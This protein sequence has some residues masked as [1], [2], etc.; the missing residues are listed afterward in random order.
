MTFHRS[1]L[2]N[3]RSTGALPAQPIRRRIIAYARRHFFTHGFRIITMDDLATELG[4]S[5]KTLFIHFSSK[6][7]LLRAV[8]LDKFDDLNA[9]LDRTTSR[10]V[11]DFPS[12]LLEL[13]SCLQRH[14]EEIQPPFLRD[15]RRE[16]PD[17]FALIETKRRELILQYFGKVVDQG[18]KAG[19]IR[20]G[21]PAN[22]VIEILLG[23]VQ[24]IMNPQKIKEIGLTLDAGYITIIRVVLEGVMTEKGRSKLPRYRGRRTL[25]GDS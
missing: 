15:M 19:L 18:Q 24:A 8:L 20:K 25:S 23:A 22:L 12:S 3:E 9:D 1:R 16:N 17:V 11:S 14:M 6:I 21:V 7:A 4:M 10:D 5:K 13:L 2:S